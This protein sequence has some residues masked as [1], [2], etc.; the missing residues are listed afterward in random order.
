M[1]Q[2]ITWENRFGFSQLV[3]SILFMSQLLF[4]L[5]KQ[6]S[7][8]PTFFLCFP[9]DQFHFRKSFKP[10]AKN[11]HRTEKAAASCWERSK[12]IV[13]CKLKFQRKGRK[14]AVANPSS[15]GKE[16]KLQLQTQVLKER[17]KFL[18]LQTK[19]LEEMKEICNYK[20][21]SSKNTS[22]RLV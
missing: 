12:K 19:V 20:P 3:L 6:G 2:L 10:I 8:H 5:L 15:R 7:T 18:Q 11:E 9:S 17:K 13:N 16:E 21:T 22:E 4:L 1:K 14:F